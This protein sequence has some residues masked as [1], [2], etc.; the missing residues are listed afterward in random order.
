MLKKIV[1]HKIKSIFMLIVSAAVAV[2]VCAYI[3]DDYKQKQA[4]IMQQEHSLLRL[5]YLILENFL[6]DKKN[7]AMTIASV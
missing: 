6:S 2:I 1:P 4:R 5:R 3:Q 7:Q